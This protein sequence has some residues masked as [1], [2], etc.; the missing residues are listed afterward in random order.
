MPRSLIYINQYLSEIQSQIK[1]KSWVFPNI[2][3][4]HN[5]VFSNYNEDTNDS[6]CIVVRVGF[7]IHSAQMK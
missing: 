5:V 7:P 1:Q 4:V 6:N 3:C 2:K